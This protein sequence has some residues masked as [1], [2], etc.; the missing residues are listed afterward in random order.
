MKLCRYAIAAVIGESIECYYKIVFASPILIQY[1]SLITS[2]SHDLHASS[3]VQPLNAY[4][5]ARMLC[6][7][8]THGDVARP[9]HMRISPCM[10]QPA[11]DG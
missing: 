4:L 6:F 5:H 10:L 9:T 1:I 3:L 2:Q 11:Q 7:A 8:V